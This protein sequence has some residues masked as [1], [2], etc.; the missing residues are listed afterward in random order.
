MSKGGACQIMSGSEI[1]S[2]IK[3]S[4]AHNV[5]AEKSDGEIKFC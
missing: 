2:N 5:I 1:M 4:M 3:F